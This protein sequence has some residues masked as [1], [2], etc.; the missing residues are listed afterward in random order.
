MSAGVWSAPTPRIYAGIF[1][2][3]HTSKGPLVFMFK[4]RPGSSVCPK[5]CAIVL[6]CSESCTC[7]S[8]PGKEEQSQEIMG[9]T[10][11][12]LLG[13]LCP[14]SERGSEGL[15]RNWI[16]EKRVVKNCVSWEVIICVWGRQKDILLFQRPRQN[17]A[18][19][20]TDVSDDWRTESLKNAR[21]EKLLHQRTPGQQ[22]VQLN[23]QCLNDC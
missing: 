6:V 1:S 22:T 9:D 7:Y 18:V 3:K 19:I 23:R 13:L 14:A 5:L 17:V 11:Q 8:L 16:V 10:W 12:K 20:L 4:A 15:S 21:M 2:R